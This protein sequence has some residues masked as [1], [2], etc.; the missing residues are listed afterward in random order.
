MEQRENLDG[1]NADFPSEADGLVVPIAEF[2][3]EDP[4]ES[5][6]D[7]FC[8]ENDSTTSGW[9]VP[10]VSTKTGAR[11]SF[12]AGNAYATADKILPMFLKL[13][14]G[15]DYGPRVHQGSAQARDCL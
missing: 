2:G 3:L 4:A 13:G 5:F 1:E 15:T 12:L 7:A 11:L 9:N 10:P 8:V 14:F 6:L